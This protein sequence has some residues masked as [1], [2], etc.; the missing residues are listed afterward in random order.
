MKNQ[1]LAQ[2]GVIEINS[3]STSEMNGG[4]LAGDFGYVCGTLVGHATNAAEMLGNI[5]YDA[6]KSLSLQ[7]G[8]RR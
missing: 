8:I 7:K 4:S 1:N 5:A 3:S 2:W 6:V